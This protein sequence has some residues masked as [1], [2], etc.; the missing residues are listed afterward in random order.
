[1][2]RCKLNHE[3]TIECS[4]E[5]NTAI[6]TIEEY[7]D[8]DYDVSYYASNRFKSEFGV[9]PTTIRILDSKII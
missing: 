3:Y 2:A 5:E 8:D 7:Y 1:M 6:Y 4:D 9:R